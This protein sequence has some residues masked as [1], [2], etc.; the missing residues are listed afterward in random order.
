MLDTLEGNQLRTIEL[1]LWEPSPL[2][3][4]FARDAVSY[5]KT[6]KGAKCN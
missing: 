5:I 6:V 3:E 4:E 2:G 1:H